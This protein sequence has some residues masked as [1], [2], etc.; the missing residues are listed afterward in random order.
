MPLP[1]VANTFE[2]C[3]GTHHFAPCAAGLVT[4]YAVHLTLLALAHLQLEMRTVHSTWGGHITWVKVRVC[5][6]QAC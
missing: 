1:L 6:R 2:L 4:L 3:R 5:V